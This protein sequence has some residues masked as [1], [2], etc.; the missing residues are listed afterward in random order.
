MY[1]T[2]QA[3]CLNF[4]PQAPA[5]AQ[6]Q[7]QY[8]AMLNAESTIMSPASVFPAHTIPSIKY[9]PINNGLCN[10]HVSVSDPVVGAEGR[11]TL[12]LFPLHPE[13]RRYE[14]SGSSLTSVS[15]SASPKSPSDRAEE[16]GEGAGGEHQYL[17]DFLGALIG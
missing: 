6:A 4:Y 15:V 7:V 14:L 5:Q 9:A 13:N 11:E 2:P 10:S 12:Q 8:S 3:G 16:G 1:A 17:F